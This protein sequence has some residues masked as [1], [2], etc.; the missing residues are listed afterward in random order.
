MLVGEFNRA[1]RRRTTWIL[2]TSGAA[3]RKL[4]DLNS[5]D[6]YKDPGTPIMRRGGRGTGGAVPGAAVQRGDWIYLSGAGASRNGDF[7]FL[8]RFNLKTGNTER[9][10]QCQGENYEIDRGA[11]Q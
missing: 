3:P 1:N 8:D 10:W 6:R 2:D 4:W 9:L 7:P 5:E 11:A